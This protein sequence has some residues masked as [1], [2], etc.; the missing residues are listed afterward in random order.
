MGIPNSPRGE[1]LFAGDV[2]REL[3]V[4][5]GLNGSIVAR[6][7]RA[8]WRKNAGRAKGRAD[9]KAGRIEILGEVDRC[10]AA[11]LARAVPGQDLLLS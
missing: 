11:G 7:A 8:E 9:G 1:I 6:F 2:A 5:P 3:Q 10:G 4:G